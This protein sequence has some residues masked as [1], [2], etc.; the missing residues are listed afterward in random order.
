MGVKRIKL[1]KPL[2]ALIGSNNGQR[3]LS[4]ANMRDKTNAYMN[5]AASYRLMSLE[6]LKLLEVKGTYLIARNVVIK[7]LQDKA[8]AETLA[9]EQEEQDVTNPST[10]TE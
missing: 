6:E 7:E 2:E 8:L 3:K 9:K 10:I 4:K 1:R 5:K